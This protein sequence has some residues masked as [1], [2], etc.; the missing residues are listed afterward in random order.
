MICILLV[1]FCAN[2]QE[3]KVN[4]VTSDITDLSAKMNPRYASDGS[5]CALLKITCPQ[6][7]ISFQAQGLVGE[8]EYGV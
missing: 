1:T 2:A 8:I 7:G 3:M 5:P 4:S 6:S